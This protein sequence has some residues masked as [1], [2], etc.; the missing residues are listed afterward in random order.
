MKTRTLLLT[1]LSCVLL[2]AISAVAETKTAIESNEDGEL[3][4]TQPTRVGNLTLQPDTYVVKDHASHGQHFIRFMHVK[5]SKDLRT[6]RAF[7]GWVTNTELI[8]AGDVKCR[9][10][11]LGAKAET[12]ALTITSEDGTPRISQ[13]TIRGKK[14]VYVF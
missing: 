5:K 13:L 4:L 6:T 10:Q 3:T 2:L 9:L 7:T 1:L 11:P 14:A 8:K 12:T